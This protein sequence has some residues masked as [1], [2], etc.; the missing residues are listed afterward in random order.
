M[1]QQ[2]IVLGHII[3]GKGI[4]VDK[5]K[6]DL[7]RSLPSP[8]SVKEIR[9]FLGHAGFYRRFIMDFS[10]ITS[11]LCNLHQ[12][13]VAFEFNEKCLFEFKKLKESLTSTPIIQPFNWELPFEIMCDTSDY[14]VRAILGQ[15]VGKVPHDI[16]YASQTLNDAQLNYFTTEKELLAVIFALEKFRSYL[17]GTKVIVYNNHAALKYLLAKKEAKPRLNQWILLLQEFD[18]EIKDKRPLKSYQETLHKLRRTR[19]S[20]MLSFIF[21]MS[22]I[23]GNIALIKS[24]EGVN[25]ILNF[26]LSLLSHILM[27][28]EVILDPRE[29]L[30]KY[31]TAILTG[32]PS[33][34][35][36]MHIARHVTVVNDLR[37]IMCISGWKQKQL[38]RIILKQW[39]SSFDQIS[40]K[41]WSIRLDDAL[42]AYHS[43]YK[44]QLGMSPYRLVYG[45]PCHLPFELEHKAWWA[46]KKCNME[47]DNARQ[48]R[49]LQLQE[50]EEI[51]NDAYESSKI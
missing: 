4:G 17:I 34:K 43:T 11:P 3:S 9:S 23:Y 47:M 27:L 1:V 15:R 6:I 29:Q 8:S 46:V 10:K 18:L 48:K 14:A 35:I 49:M 2:G 36:H 42:W 5:E 50:L 51:R 24:F 30:I 33:L 7:I 25:M 22:L 12:K 40:L 28:V 45:K 41:D 21:W 39:L 38:K 20:M 31:L 19:L 26:N 37:W 32:L 44:T 16:Y 13:D